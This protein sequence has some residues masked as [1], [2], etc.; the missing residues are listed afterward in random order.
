MAE[1]ATPFYIAQSSL[2]Y[3]GP[4]QATVANRQIYGADRHRAVAARPGNNRTDWRF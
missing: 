1:N 3:Y 4:A 2:K